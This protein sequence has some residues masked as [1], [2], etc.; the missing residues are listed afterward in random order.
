MNIAQL[1]LT[2]ARQYRDAPAITF[3]GAT[4]SFGELADRVSRMAAGLQSGLGLRAGDRAV[5]WM[6]NRPEFLESLFACWIAGVCAVPANAKLHPR[7]VAHIIRDADAKAIFTTPSLE[8]G[9]LDQFGP[10]RPHPL[11]VAADSP[12]YHSLADGVTALCHD[13]APTDPAWIFYTSGTTGFPKGAI[14][15][16]RNLLF[17]SLAYYADIEQVAPGQTMV[18]AAPLSHG[19]GQYLLP[20]LFGG[21]HQLILPKFD[22]LEVLRAC[23][24]YEGVSMFAVPTM[25]TRM[26]QSL[27]QIP[28]WTGNVRTI[29]YG[30]APMYVADLIKAMDVFGP[31]LYQLYGQGESPMTIC[32]LTQREHKE[33]LDA[34]DIARLA[35]CGVPRSGVEIRILD[36]AGREVA[37]GE[38]GEV[39]TRSDCVMSGY[40]NNPEAT[41]SALRDGW[42]STGDVGL[43]DGRGY[44]VLR[45]RSKDMIISGGTNIYPREIEEVLM[46]HPAVSECAVVGRPHGDLGEEPVAFVVSR[47]GMEV[48]PAE[49]DALCL[50]HM[51]RFKR[52]RAYRFIDSLPKS[53]YGKIL[54]SELRTLLQ[55]I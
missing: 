47:E 43:I 50:K 15:S 10:G 44:L 11:V 27:A 55:I 2:R 29:I 35:S 41:A 37:P 24:E 38:L 1:L 30:G 25:I 28:G 46:L 9:L 26:V 7:E 31:C 40:W 3:A 51:A 20:H 17:M 5:L 13:A 48:A 54:K 52:P 8:S 14:L 32:G 6:E 12:E 33:A 16:H 42:L 45:D 19:S 49:L 39:A 22:A 21:G 18:H 36:P 4:T 34:G 53:S 23:A